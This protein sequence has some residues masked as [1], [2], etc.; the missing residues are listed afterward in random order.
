MLLPFVIVPWTSPVDRIVYHEG[1]RVALDRL[2]IL[3]DDE[4]TRADV[5]AAIA[6]H[7]G[8]FVDGYAVLEEAGMYVA[9]FPVER[10]EELESIQLALESVGIRASMSWVGELFA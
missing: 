4:Q 7:G 3:A 5:E 10:I 8:T 6:P 1:S 9:R 2:I